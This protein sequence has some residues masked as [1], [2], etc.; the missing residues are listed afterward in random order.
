MRVELIKCNY[1]IRTLS[2]LFAFL[3]LLT[4]ALRSTSFISSVSCVSVGLARIMGMPVSTSDRRIQKIVTKEVA[5]KH[6]ILTPELTR[7]YIYSSLKSI[8]FLNKTWDDTFLLYILRRYLCASN[9]LL[10]CY[11]RYE[12]IFASWSLR[13]HQHLCVSQG[14]IFDVY[15]QWLVK[16][17]AIDF[18]LSYIENREI[19]T[20]VQPRRQNWRTQAHDTFYI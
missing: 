20:K 12:F 17:V 10:P 6:R 9:Y 7:H 5:V 13:H 18:I 8:F 15:F 4:R 16:I 1:H 11:T 19:F 14:N 2:T 3:Y